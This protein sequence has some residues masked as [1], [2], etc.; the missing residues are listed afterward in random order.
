MPIL[1]VAGV[2]ILAGVLLWLVNQYLP[3]QAQVKSLLNVVVV[4]LL[5][6][7]IVLMLLRAFGPGPSI[8]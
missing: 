7:W 8:G 3:M 6:L 4:G 5:A 1:Y 2:I